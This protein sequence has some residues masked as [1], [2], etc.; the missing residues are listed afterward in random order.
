LCERQEKSE[1]IASD[2]LKRKGENP[3]MLTG[4]DLTALPTWHQYLK[5]AGM[6]KDA[7]FVTWREIKRHGKAPPAFEKWT[8]NDKEKLNEAHLTK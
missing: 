1:S 2:I 4:T 6:K 5:V 3:T 7:K 8:H